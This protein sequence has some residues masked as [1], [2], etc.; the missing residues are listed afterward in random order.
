[1][2]DFILESLGQQHHRARQSGMDA[3]Q[4]QALAAGRKA[5]AAY[6]PDITARATWVRM[7]AWKK[8]C[9]RSATFWVPTS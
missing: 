2:M 4:R 1:M 9:A 5:E 3:G 8:C 6:L 7:C